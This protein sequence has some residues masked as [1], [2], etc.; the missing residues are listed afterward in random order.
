MGQGFFRPVKDRDLIVHWSTFWDFPISWGRLDEFALEPDQ[1]ARLERSGSTWADEPRNYSDP[2][3]GLIFRFPAN[4][5]EISGYLY[6]DN[7]P[8]VLDLILTPE[9]QER[10]EK[11]TAL[12]IEVDE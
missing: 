10:T 9:S 2:T 7:V 11:L 1:L 3:D 5:T 8:A 4:Q 6:Y 12:M